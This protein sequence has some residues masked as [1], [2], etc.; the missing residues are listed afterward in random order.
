MTKIHVQSSYEDG[1]SRV[2]IPGL[3]KR[4]NRFQE[5]QGNRAW[6]ASSLLILMSQKDIIP[7]IVEENGKNIEIVY[8]KEDV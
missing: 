1:Y 6:T 4:F 7:E 2:Q 8:V 3:V 5:K